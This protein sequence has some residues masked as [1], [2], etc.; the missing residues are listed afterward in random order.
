MA[1]EN[2]GFP[3]HSAIEFPGTVEG[4]DTAWLDHKTL[5]VGRSYR[6]NAEGID[7]VSLLLLAVVL[8][9]DLAFS[10]APR[11]NRSGWR[12]SSSTSH[13]FAARTTSS[14]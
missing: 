6:T 7:Q 11:W 3:V 12:F 9:S 2:L 8:A 5:A 14:I 4:G 13:T 1:L 10:S